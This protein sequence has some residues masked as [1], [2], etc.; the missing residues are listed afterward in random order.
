MSGKGVFHITSWNE[1]T[2]QTFENGGKLATAKVTQSYEGDIKG[3]SELH[4]LMQY[5][6]SGNA[7]FVGYERICGTINDDPC[8]LIIKHNG[9]FQQ[10]VARST[11]VVLADSIPATLEGKEGSFESTEGGKAN[12]LIN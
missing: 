2:E 4:Y 10:G 5:E 12:Y 8:T 9:T 7:S 11:F 3:E 6:A 1:S